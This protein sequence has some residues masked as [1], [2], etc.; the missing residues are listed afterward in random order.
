VAK[1]KT[2]TINYTYD[3]LVKKFHMLSWEKKLV[4]IHEAVADDVPK[5]QRHTHC[6][7]PY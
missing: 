6:G 1:S 2:H 5:N 3:V 4:T 7:K